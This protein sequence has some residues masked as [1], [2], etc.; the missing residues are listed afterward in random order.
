M[1]N[2]SILKLIHI[3]TFIISFAIGMFFVYTIGAETK[4][5]YVYPTP[6]NVNKIQYKES[7]YQLR[8]SST[9]EKK[10]KQRYREKQNKRAK[11]RACKK[12]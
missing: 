3:P 12:D 4:I 6:D 7:R 10:I 11:R 8:K 1:E 5:I 2:F 9:E